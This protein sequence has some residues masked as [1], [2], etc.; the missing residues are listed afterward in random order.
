MALLAADLVT[1]LDLLALDSSVLKE[2]GATAFNAKRQIAVTDWLR[3]RLEAANLPP[4]KHMTRRQPDAAFH[5][6]ELSNTWEDITVRLT[7]PSEFYLNSLLAQPVYD[8]LYIGMREPYRGLWCG[9]TDSVNT[10]STTLAVAYWS[11]QWTQFGSGTSWRDNTQSS[12]GRSFTKGGR[13]GWTLPEDWMPRGINNTVAYWVKLSVLSSLTVTV[14]QQILPVTRSRLTDPLAHY[15]LGLIYRVAIANKRGEWEAKAKLFLDLAK[16]NLDAV[17]PYIRD[18]FDI[19][20]DQAVERIEV[21]SM[22]LDPFT[23]ERG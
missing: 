15:T 16:T 2:F 21:N 17:L 6:N 12:V 4:D 7:G 9:L 8:R 11:G 23:F 1:D 22:T 18:E 19:D 10:N 13:V 20:N 5:Y 14:A 3:P